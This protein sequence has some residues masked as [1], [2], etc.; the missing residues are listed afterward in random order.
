VEERYGVNGWYSKVLYRT[1]DA[2]WLVGWFVVGGSGVQIFLDGR[3]RK[4]V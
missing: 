1:F 4:L 3:S 2:I